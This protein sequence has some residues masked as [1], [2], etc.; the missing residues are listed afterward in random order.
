MKLDLAQYRDLEAFAQFGSDLDAA[1]QAQLARG[2][3]LVATLNQDQYDPW[4]VEEQVAVIWS[5]SNGYVDDVPVDQVVPFNEG[6]R[7]HLSSED[8]ALSAIRESYA[9][10][11]EAIAALK[12]AV[13]DYKAGYQAEH[14]RPAPEPAGAAA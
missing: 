7:R 2:Q 13:E 12:A 5:T 8:T 4:A 14:E 6:L 1:T 3:R 11:D 10:T 9:L